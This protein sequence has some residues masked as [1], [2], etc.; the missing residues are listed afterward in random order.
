MDGQGNV[1]NLI[2]EEWESKKLQYTEIA[3]KHLKACKYVKGNNS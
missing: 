3:E 2:K 1:Q